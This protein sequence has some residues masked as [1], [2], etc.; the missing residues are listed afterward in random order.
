M[1]KKVFI[2]EKITEKHLKSMLEQEILK[3]HKMRK[4]RRFTESRENPLEII[5]INRKEI[6]E[7]W[8]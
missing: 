7:K 5:E 6:K 8:N 2:Q 4:K 3:A 1:E